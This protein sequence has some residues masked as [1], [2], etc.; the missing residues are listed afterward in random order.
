MFC[1]L[2]F[3]S[4]FVSEIFT[5]L[6]LKPLKEVVYYSNIREHDPLD[7][8]KPLDPGLAQL[9]KRWTHLDR[10]LVV[11]A[12]RAREA[13]NPEKRNRGKSILFP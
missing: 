3:F 12:W 9:P 10:L 13:Q 8:A 1:L 2:F 6:C 5:I 11:G 7:D 4:I